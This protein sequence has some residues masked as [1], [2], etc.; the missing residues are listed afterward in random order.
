MK[1]P[2]EEKGFSLVELMIAVSIIA[3]ALLLFIG[4]FFSMFKS[5]QKG[6]DLTAGIVVAE[7]ALSEYLYDRQEMSGGLSTNLVDNVGS[8]ITGTTTL[9]KTI[10]T[11]EITCQDV[12][13]GNLKKIDVVVWWWQDTA[14]KKEFKSGYGK[15]NVSISRLIYSQNTMNIIPSN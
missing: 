8:P 15:L 3:T 2:P 7:S 1:K 13:T 5:S 14:L 6:V 9:N 4:V 12:G 11:Y 10:F